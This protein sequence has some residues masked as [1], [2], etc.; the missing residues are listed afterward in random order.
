MTDITFLLDTT[1]EYQEF[2]AY[3][4]IILNAVK[5][6]LIFDAG[7]GRIRISIIRFA[8]GIIVEVPLTA[9]P[10]KASEES[11]SRIITTIQH[12]PGSPSTKAIQVAL[13]G[14]SKFGRPEAR[15]LLVVLSSSPSVVAA[16]AEGRIQGVE[17]FVISLSQEALTEP[18]EIRLYRR[19]S[20]PFFTV[21]LRL[22]CNTVTCLKSLNRVEGKGI[23]SFPSLPNDE[24][25]PITASPESLPFLRPVDFAE[26]ENSASFEFPDP[27]PPS[28]YTQKS[29]FQN[30][31]GDCRK[32]V[33]DIIIVMDTSSRVTAKELEQEKE[34]VWDLLNH[35]YATTPKG[36]SVSFILFS[37]YARYKLTLS[38]YRNREAVLRALSEILHT[39]GGT[40]TSEAVH[41]ATEEINRAG[42]SEATQIIVLFSSGNSADMWPD[43]SPFALAKLYTII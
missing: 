22:I 11:I 30:V 20:L 13:N 36:L 41:L 39:G 31:E 25:N 23:H 17:T 4:S 42:R 43:V 24:V 16:S 26:E 34:L 35:L 3:R 5:E 27:V 15:P 8:E 1:S 33:V 9:P 14:F 40:V 28:A 29:E 6:L 38:P 37:T 12:T 32:S 10:L 7:L 19:A 21:N 18:P 2:L